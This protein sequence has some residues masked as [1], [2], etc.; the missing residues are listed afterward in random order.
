LVDT[1]RVPVDAALGAAL[2]PMQLQV[3]IDPAFTAEPTVAA[4]PLTEVAVT[5]RFP[6]VEL[7]EQDGFDVKTVPKVTDM[8]S[9]FKVV[10]EA[11]LYDEAVTK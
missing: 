1:V 11:N 4:K 7:T 9:L 5:V 8:I 3:K 6:E 2:A 10:G